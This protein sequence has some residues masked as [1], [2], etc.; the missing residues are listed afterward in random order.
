MSNLSTQSLLQAKQG[1]EK[2]FLMAGGWWLA[3]AK[4][5]AVPAGRAPEAKKGGSSGQAKPRGGSIHGQ[6]EATFLL[7]LPK[8]RGRKR[9][10]RCLSLGTLYFRRS[11]ELSVLS[12]ALLSVVTGVS[13]GLPVL[14]GRWSQGWDTAATASGPA[15]CGRA[16]PTSFSLSEDGAAPSPPTASLPSR[17]L[18]HV[19][20]RLCRHR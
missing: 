10:L 19:S 5:C 1:D 4:G 13:P 11:R 18:C 17:R 6:G 7:F 20:G 9:T 14:C 3:P 8:P 16:A 12:L 2:L 15:L